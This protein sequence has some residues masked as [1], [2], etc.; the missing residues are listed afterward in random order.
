MMFFVCVLD[1]FFINHFTHFTIGHLKSGIRLADFYGNCYVGEGWRGGWGGA[2]LV[3][4]N[5][6]SDGRVILI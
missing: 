6:N 1:F 2:V 5:F 4:Y 3:D